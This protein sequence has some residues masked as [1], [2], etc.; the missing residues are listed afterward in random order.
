MNW[1]SYLRVELGRLFRSKAIWL[2]LG[3][4]ALSP[5][6]G[7]FLYTPAATTTTAG[8][9]LA[10]PALAGGLAGAFLFAALTLY[11]LNR[12][13][14]HQMEP[15][16]DSIVSPVLQGTVKLLALL[17]TA[18]FT[19][20]LAAAVQL[21]YTL[22][23]LGET[24]SAWEYCRAYGLFLT[25]PL[26]MGVL[27]A[28]GFYQIFRRIDLSFICFTVLAFVSMS[29]WFSD[30]YLMRWIN[31][32]VPSFSG[33]LGNTSLFR[34]ALYSRLMWL[35]LFTGFWLFS[36][37]CVRTHGKRLPGSLLL[38]ARRIS[39]PVLAAALIGGGCWLSAVQPY[40]DREPPRKAEG[41]IT[42]GG[43]MTVVTS[44]GESTENENL[45]LLRTEVDLRVDAWAGKAYGTARYHLENTGGQPQ[46]CRMDLNPG[47]T[48]E[49][50]AVNGVEIPFEDLQN[51]QWLTKKNVV[52]TL[53]AERELEVEVTY[54][55]RVQIASNAG[56]IMVYDEI[57][58]EYISLGGNNAA[59]G[60]Q[61]AIVPGCSFTGT[62]RLP[63]EMELI[64]QGEPAQV[65][66]NAD[67][68]KLWS[69]Q[70]AGIRPT[71]FAGNYIRLE[72]K[73][74]EFPVYFCYSRSH[75]KQFEAL[76]IERILTDT[77][78]YCTE[79]YGPLPYTEEQPLNIVMT[80][81]HM[82]GGGAKGNLSFM[83]ETFFTQ[84]SLN[85][86]SKGASAAEIISHEI[87]HQWWGISRFLLDLEN[88]DWS[89]EALTV[90]TTYRLAKKLY[91]AD[92]AQRYYVD[93]WQESWKEQNDNF[94]LRHPEY[95]A[96][97]PEKYQASLLSLVS[98][99]ATYAKAPLQV[100]KAER[101]VGGEAQMDEI[102]KGL[103]QQG[104]T[105]MPP[106]LTW[107]DFLDACGLT[108][109][110]LNLEGGWQS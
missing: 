63:E 44:G 38:N 18:L 40:A 27:L 10:N 62:V 106:Y 58:P 96:M 1:L 104:G 76:D 34:M 102:L 97:L 110:Q 39:L 86:S 48:V 22:Y 77:I 24:F 26:W 37:L 7:L 83:G 6:A 13:R 65:L 45:T 55:G 60:L 23:R 54:G 31:P 19:A 88:P 56:M 11:E 87:I 36:L 53:P 15:L 108:E 71:I 2:I 78:A 66:E 105:E 89:S 90:Y 29:P 46:E 33:D 103:F 57:T 82:M 3:L 81:A 94:Y 4:T 72:I 75:Q 61:T 9:V 99:T 98:Q 17:V 109:E 74:Q 41:G 67:G 80:N 12:V 95:Q 73:D 100:L 42:T 59:P 51:D 16:T 30:S 68:T 79:L 107:Q 32:A 8:A 52:F 85:D 49:R 28:A 64:S 101:L 35:A 69:L 50:I 25:P 14:K 43:G 91:G 21:P 93:L 47:Y 70:G 84:E 20:L 5:L 92:Y